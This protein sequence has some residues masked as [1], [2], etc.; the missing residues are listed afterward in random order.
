MFERIRDWLAL[1]GRREHDRT[2]P[3]APAEP[4]LTPEE[5]TEAR[6]QLERDERVPAD[7]PRE[8]S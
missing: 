5:E 3:T 7:E 1:R 4:E 6:K 8:D 2:F